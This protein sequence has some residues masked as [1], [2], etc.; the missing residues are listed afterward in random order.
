MSRE[1]VRVNVGFA[2]AFAMI[3][4]PLEDQSLEIDVDTLVAVLESL[5][6]YAEITL[7]FI[8]GNERRVFDLMARDIPGPGRRFTNLTHGTEW[9][10]IGS[11]IIMDKSVKYIT[12]SK[13]GEEYPMLFVSL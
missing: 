10:D 12:T 3:A 8:V 6:S 1:Q 7:T 11:F 13:R 4:P 5:P 2:R 9:F